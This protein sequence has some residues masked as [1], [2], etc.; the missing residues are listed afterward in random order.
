MERNFP[1]KAAI[2]TGQYCST[3]DHWSYQAIRERLL[4]RFVPSGPFAPSPPNRCLVGQIAHCANQNFI[5]SSC[6]GPV[7]LH[8]HQSD[9][10]G[11][12]ADSPTGGLQWNRNSSQISRLT[13]FAI[14]A[15][16]V[17]TDSTRSAK[18]TDQTIV[19]DS[20]LMNQAVNHG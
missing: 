6:S 3:S 10:H 9:F 12:T 5:L 16:T 15:W 17:K 20:A 2:T 11:S 1:S 18:S 14:S 19:R 8:P 13:R 7:A 4:Q